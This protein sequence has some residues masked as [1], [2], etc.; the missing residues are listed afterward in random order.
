M[1][2]CAAYWSLARSGRFSGNYAGRL[3]LFRSRM[4][5][6]MTPGCPSPERGHM[7]GPLDIHCYLL[8]YDVSHEI[9]RLRR[10]VAHA[11]ELPDALGVPADRCVIAHPFSAEHAGLTRLTILLAPASTRLELLGCQTV[12]ARLLQDML[13]VPVTVRP[14][15]A[16][17]VS[18]H[19]DY[20]ASHL[21]PLLLPNDVP[22]FATPSLDALGAVVIYTATGD[23]G[24]ALAIP[25]GDLIT[26]VGARIAPVET[27]NLIVLEPTTRRSAARLPEPALHARLDPRSTGVPHPPLT[28]AI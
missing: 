23:S 25:A 27:R 19:T 24:T 12:L 5:N 11:Q 4:P 17:L 8:D 3:F 28:A 13:D 20:V 22:V 9:V 18:R 15:G 21:A 1:Y 7:K 10:P 2:F 26:L 6:V 16:E 14:A